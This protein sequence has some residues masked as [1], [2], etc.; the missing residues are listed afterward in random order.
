LS[1]GLAVDDSQVY[2]VATNSGEE[3]WRMQPSNGVTNRSAYGAASLLTGALLWEVA[4]PAN[5]VAYGYPSVV[6]DLVIVGRTGSDPNGTANYDATQGGLVAT[7][8]A[9]GVVL[10]DHG[11][12]TTFHGG[13]A[14]QDRYMLFG[15][16]YWG[17]GPPGDVPG[18]INV[19]RVG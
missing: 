14:I 13:V 4:V 5:G 7:D 16:G 19:M 17:F 2:F 10:L 3:T 1:W 8:K 18:A 9:T 6:G 12:S 15:T 11:L